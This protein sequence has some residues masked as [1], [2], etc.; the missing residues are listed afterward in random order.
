MAP[1]NIQRK[2]FL[3]FPKGA[4]SVFD[5]ATGYLGTK[6]YFMLT[7][8]YKFILVLEGNGF[9]THRLW[10]VL[11]QGSF[12]VVLRTPWSES[13][14]YLGLP[15]CY[16]ENFS[17]LDEGFLENF[18]QSNM[19][20]NPQLCSELWTNYWKDLVGELTEN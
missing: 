1:T 16:V 9:D 6:K 18:L 12:P 17:A 11:Y 7:R 10:E 19:G 4:D 15:I 14:E 20:F 8:R 5:V 13:L 2:D 3:A